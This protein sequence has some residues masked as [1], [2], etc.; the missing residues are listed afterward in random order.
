MKQVVSFIRIPERVQPPPTCTGKVP[1]FSPGSVVP[2]TGAQSGRRRIEMNIFLTALGCKLNQAE[3]ETM[4]RQV[5]AA[6]HRLVLI[7]QEA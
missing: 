7:P 5:E 1:R 2:T 4:A 6:G 3:I